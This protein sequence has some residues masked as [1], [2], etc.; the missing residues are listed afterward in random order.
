MLKR[1]WKPARS[2]AGLRLL[3]ADR[4]EG[5]RG[6]TTRASPTRPDCRNWLIR[7]P[8]APDVRS[9]LDRHLVGGLFWVRCC[10]IW[11]ACSAAKRVADCR[12]DLAHHVVADSADEGG[13]RWLGHGVDA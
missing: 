7:Q 9:I 2:S 13:E 10:L 4:P 11:L 6:S 12:A 1:L 8:L 3:L 5:D